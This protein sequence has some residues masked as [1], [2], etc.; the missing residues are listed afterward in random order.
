M[1][2]WQVTTRILHIINKLSRQY[3]DTDSVRNTFTDDIT[4]GYCLLENLSLMI[5]ILSIIL[6][7]FPS[8]SIAYRRQKEPFVILFVIYFHIT[9]RS[10]L[11]VSTYC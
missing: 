3:L 4:N 6:S 9:N 5:S 8:V 10:K 1:H 7:I 2:I 11:S